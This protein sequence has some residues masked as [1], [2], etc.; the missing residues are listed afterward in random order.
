VTRDLRAPCALPLAIVALALGAAKAPERARPAPIP[1]EEGVE[2]ELSSD[3]RIRVRSG[4]D[5][6]LE[7]LPAPNEG[8]RD[9]ARRVTGLEERAEEI[10]AY[11]GGAPPS[12][13]FARV[14]LTMLSS[15][16]RSLVLRRLFPRDRRDGADWIHVARSGVLSTY[17]EGLWQI[18]L[19]FTGDGSRFPE[20]QRTNGLASPELA[21]GQEVRIPAAMLDSA[22]AAATL[23]QE[24]TLQYASDARGA[25]AGYRLKAGEALYSAVVVRF[26]GRTDPD[27]VKS[28]ARE[29]GERSGIRDLTDIPIGFLVKIPLDLLEPEYLP[30]NDARR[31][32]AEKARAELAAELTRRPV[33]TGQRSLQ[34]VVVILDPG[35][36]GRDLGTM[37]HGIWE[38]DYVYDVACRLRQRLLATTSAQV[39]MTLEDD[40]TGCAPS[41]GDRLSANREGTI[42]TT[43]PFLARESGES[44]VA[45]NLRWYLANSIF[46]KVTKSGV[47]PDRVV[48]LSLHAD[49]RHPSLRGVMVY[50]PGSSYRDGTYGSRAGVYGRFQEVREQPTI[51]FSRRDRVRSEAVSRRL[52]TRIVDGF[53]K[54]GLAVQKYQPIRERVIRGRGTWLP[55]VLRGNA[56]PAKVL[57]EMVNL[58]NAEDAGV[59]AAA[60]ERD[61]LATALLDSLVAYLGP[62]ADGRAGVP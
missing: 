51:R 39:F 61:S 20:I 27:D 53:R 60:A 48:F 58:S 11:N 30:G 4:R 19:W 46:R 3:L 54:E 15:D 6:E 40:K 32:E 55:A 12:G 26:T 14:P 42:R 41:A 37:S 10:A 28:V 24:G 34:G 5:L 62:G 25:Y 8:Y 17:G 43:P 49:A 44:V 22:F 31:I 33:R 21:A 9:V 38:H 13:R 47:D 2:L 50:V 35:H 36:G 7:V 52:A 29:I 16:Y 59:L 56:V 23:S 57:V 18:A 1:L 45:V